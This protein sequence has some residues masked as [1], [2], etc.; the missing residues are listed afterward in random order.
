MGLGRFASS[1]VSVFTGFFFIPPIFFPDFRRFF[2]I[3][4]IRPIRW[5]EINS[6]YILIFFI[7]LL[8]V[9]GK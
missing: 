3:S 9:K 7:F 6:T 5:G 4:P 1:Q 2:K 8:I